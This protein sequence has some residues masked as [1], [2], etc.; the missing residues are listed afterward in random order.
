MNKYIIYT[1]FLLFSET[2]Q[3]KIEQNKEDANVFLLNYTDDSSN[4]KRQ[5]ILGAP[6]Y[7]NLN[8]NKY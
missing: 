1:C 7:N 3:I 4:S 2:T 5:T 6:K 8:N